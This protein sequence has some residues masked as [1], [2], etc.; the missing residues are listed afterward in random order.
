LSLNQKNNNPNLSSSLSFSSFS[1]FEKIPNSSKKITTSLTTTNHKYECTK[2]QGLWPCG[3][4][5]GYAGGIVSSA[6]DGQNVAES[7]VSKL[8]R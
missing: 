7:I 2:V 4:G 1:S 3:E 5:A 8:H 6:V